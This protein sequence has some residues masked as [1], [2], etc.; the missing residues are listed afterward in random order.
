MKDKHW[1]LLLDFISVLP[2]IVGIIALILSLFNFIPSDQYLPIIF[3]LVILIATNLIIERRIRLDK[4]KTTTDKLENFLDE[5]EYVE[6][7]VFE[8]DDEG[9][10]Y[11]GKIICSASKS[12][13]QASIDFQKHPRSD[14]R[15][16]FEELRDEKI[17]RNDVKYRYIAHNDLVRRENWIKTHINNDKFSAYYFESDKKS[18][19][20][21]FSFNIIDET[22]VFTRYPFREGTKANYITIKN[23]KVAEFFRRYFDELCVSAKEFKGLSK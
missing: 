17:K 13:D 2:V 15:E 20:P 11:L 6:S 8:D 19:I 5:I 9:I 16:V 14:S 3:V 10:E 22:E 12:V 1:K 18:T 4:I 21:L 7:K 23:K